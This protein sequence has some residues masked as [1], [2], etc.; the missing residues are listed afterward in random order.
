MD[1]SIADTDAQLS[2][3]LSATAII[4]VG[5]SSISRR[6]TMPVH[7]EETGVGNKPTLVMV[8]GAGGSSATWFMQLRGLSQHLHIRAIDLN[9]HG[10]TADRKEEDVTRSYLDDIRTVVKE[11]GRP[12]LVGHSMG[13][14]LTLLYALTWPD[15]IAGLV[16]VGTGAR[17]RV[18]KLIFDMLDNNFEGYVEAVGQF[19][20]AKDTSEQLIEASQAEVRK[21][22]IEVTRRDFVVCNLFD[23][24]N[25]IKEITL[26]TLIIVGGE[27]IMTPKKYAAYLDEH[28]PNTTLA[29]ING[30]GHSV[31]LERPSEFNEIVLDWARANFD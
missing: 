12:I 15:E 26:P 20:F 27:D 14:A 24:M 9:G 17:L 11:S 31:M 18:N 7:Y 22:P 4:N 1:L 6:R 30:A 10:K 25:R 13:G 23:V 19:M 16:L 8:H 3:F 5:I 21:C 28:I 2:I 29:V